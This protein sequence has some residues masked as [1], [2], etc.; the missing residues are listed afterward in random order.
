MVSP[1]SSPSPPYNPFTPAYSSPYSPSP[2]YVPVNVRVMENTPPSPLCLPPPTDLSATFT[3]SASII[4][5]DSLVL[6][7][8]PETIEQ[9]RRFVRRHESNRDVLFRSSWFLQVLYDLSFN[10]NLRRVAQNFRGLIRP[11]HYL[12]VYTHANEP[13]LPLHVMRAILNHCRIYHSSPCSEYNEYLY[14]AVSPS[15]GCFGLAA[16]PGVEPIRTPQWELGNFIEH[17]RGLMEI[18]AFHFLAKQL[19]CMMCDT[20]TCCGVK[21]VQPPNSPEY[22]TL[23]KSTCP[24]V[25]G[26]KRLTN[27]ELITLYRVVISDVRSDVEDL[28]E[29]YYSGHFNMRANIFTPGS[30]MWGFRFDLNGGS[31]IN[32][33]TMQNELRFNIYF[34][35]NGVR[36]DID[37]I[38]TRM[39]IARYC[40]LCRN[41]DCRMF[42]RC[43]IHNHYHATEHYHERSNGNYPCGIRNSID[44]LHTVEEVLAWEDE[45]TEEEIENSRQHLEI[46]RNNHAALFFVGDSSEE[47]EQTE[48]EYE[49][50]EDESD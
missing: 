34:D 4:G 46:E 16:R 7:I 14:A 45:L 36:E 42:C 44:P 30:R 31:T 23:H 48:L 35:Q 38:A 50:D 5:G 1:P 27:E 20:T 40:T 11:T 6:R 41:H 24:F 32:V 22:L 39:G 3:S 37:N 13:A 47:E 17:K 33:I 18:A 29:D 15:C 26:I 25:W 9:F 28:N 12:N 49:Y 2:S 43:V 8:S 19:T 10:P 21:C